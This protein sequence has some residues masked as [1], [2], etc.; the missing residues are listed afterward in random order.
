MNW[1]VVLSWETSFTGDLSS[2]VVPVAKGILN[3]YKDEPV[4]DLHDSPDIILSYTHLS[5]QVAEFLE[6]SL[7]L[8]GNSNEEKTKEIE[9][10]IDS[11]SPKEW[12][13]F[14]TAVKEKISPF[15]IKRWQK[16]MRG[17]RRVWK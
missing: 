3:M 15:F 13:T 7:G 4:V 12:R 9:N 16:E 5:S 14:V 6:Y 8:T 17:L 11:I 2:Y 10:I 1:R